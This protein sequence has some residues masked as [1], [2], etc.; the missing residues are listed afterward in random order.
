MQLKTITEL[1]ALPNYKVIEELASDKQEHIHY[2]LEQI[3]TTAPVCSGCGN[4]HDNSVHSKEL[5]IV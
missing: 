4:I 2:L 3:K 1:L 5:V